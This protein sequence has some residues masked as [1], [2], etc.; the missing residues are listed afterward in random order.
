MLRS[1]A[2]KASSGDQEALNTLVAEVKQLKPVRGQVPEKWHSVLSHIV[3]LIQEFPGKEND[4]SLVSAVISFAAEFNNQVSLSVLQEA[5]ERGLGAK[6]G[7]WYSAVALKNE[8]LG[9]YVA[10]AACFRD[11]REA[12]AE[13]EVFM[14]QQFEN[15]KRRM[16]KRLNGQA[17]LELG[18]LRGAKYVFIDG[19]VE[20]R[21]E[22]T[23][24]PAVPRIDLLEEIGY[25]PDT[26]AQT[27]LSPSVTKSDLFKAGYDTS[28]LLDDFGMEQSLE[29]A[30]LK[31]LNIDFVKERQLTPKQSAFEPLPQRRRNPRAL[32][33][34]D[35]PRSNPVQ[36]DPEPSV[37]PEEPESFQ[38]VG[39]EQPRSILKRRESPRNTSRTTVRF[40]QAA[41]VHPS[42]IRRVPTP[43]VKRTA[44][45]GEMLI[46]SGSKYLCEKQLGETA[47]MCS[48]DGGKLVI[49]PLN[50]DQPAFEPENKELFCLPITSV[51][52][53]YATAF[54]KYGTFND[55]M[56]LCHQKPRGVEEPVAWFCLLQMVRMLRN[57]ENAWMT[58]G[59]ISGDTLLNRFSSQEIPKEFDLNGG[60]KE[61]GFALCRI[62]KLTPND[63]SGVDRAAVASLFHMLCTKSEMVNKPQACPRRWNNELWTET[64]DVLQSTAPFDKLIDDLVTE[65]S[66]ERVTLALRSY[67]TRYDNDI[68]TK[69]TSV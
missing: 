44:R 37:E 40:N 30:R 10:S 61:E 43:T 5:G 6:H 62:D 22:R 21:D 47:M 38:Y 24:R 54:C 17:S 2:V 66:Q 29:E 53:F 60:W 28:L 31:S 33:P 58:H 9:N 57:L 4:D 56:H 55:M 12:A 8:H 16:A 18:T 3:A 7:L 20:C 49:K 46:I 41:V 64:F 15:F 25:R 51:K 11:G 26:L 59:A 42:E 32:Q 1:L 52:E 23:N 48:G 34:L 45:V 14:K 69:Y 36:F 67:K 63:R 50:L 19:V 13:P 35:K 65:L 27:S 68:V 39:S